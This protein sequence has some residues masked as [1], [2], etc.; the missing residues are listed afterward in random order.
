MPASDSD[1][2]VSV[3]DIRNVYRKMNDV[4]TA[5]LLFAAVGLLYI[6]LGI[7]LLRGQVKPNNWSGCRT[8]KTLSNEKIWY[9]V[10]RVTGRDMIAAGI[11]VL[12]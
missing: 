9:A 11:A 2:R 10:N 1:C 8:T 4:T 5:S 12:I 6:T 7:P 3:S